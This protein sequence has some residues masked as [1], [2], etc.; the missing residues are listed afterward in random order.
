MY[1]A[2]KVPCNNYTT[3]GCKRTNMLSYTQNFKR[4][5][6]RPTANQAQRDNVIGGAAPNPMCWGPFSQHG[7]RSVIHGMPPSQCWGP[8]SQHGSRSVIHGMPPS[9]YS[10]INEIST[11]VE[12]SKVGCPQASAGSIQSAWKSICHTW[13]AQKLLFK[14]Q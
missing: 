12:L 10:R 1:S 2:T 3:L 5:L 4:H 13:D 9:C 7:S 8:F 11:E 14:D 6:E